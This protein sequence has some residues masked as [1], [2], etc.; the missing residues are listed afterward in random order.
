MTK[1]PVSEAL[2]AEAKEFKID[3]FDAA[4]EGSELWLKEN[5]AAFD[6]SNEYVTAHGLPLASHRQ[7]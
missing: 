1:V 6:D 2:L 4:E 5:K 3:I 7:F